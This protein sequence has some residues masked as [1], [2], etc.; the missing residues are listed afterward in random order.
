M[1]LNRSDGLGTASLMI[2][3]SCISFTFPLARWE[4][5]GFTSRWKIGAAIGSIE[6]LH[7]GKPHLGVGCK[8]D[9]LPMC[10]RKVMACDKLLM[11]RSEA[12]G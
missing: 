4:T 10:R 7:P 11:T 5:A 3:F 2:N 12:S 8:E 6:L 9:C 1:A